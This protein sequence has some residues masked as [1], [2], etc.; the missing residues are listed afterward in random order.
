M[1]NINSPLRNNKSVFPWKWIFLGIL[2]LLIIRIYLNKDPDLISNEPSVKKT[3]SNSIYNFTLTECLGKD[4][5][6]AATFTVDT[7]STRW[8]LNFNNGESITYD[9][10]TGNSKDPMCGL[11]AMDSYGDK[12]EICIRPE[13]GGVKIDFEYSGKKL[14]YSGYHQK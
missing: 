6:K 10:Q 3:T 12:C 2:S 14:I 11:K 7:K 1:N 13:K 8:V 4:L 5:T 9:I